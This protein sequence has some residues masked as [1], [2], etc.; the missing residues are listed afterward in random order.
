MLGQ[1][2]EHL[3]LVGVDLD[4]ALSPVTGEIGAWGQKWIDRLA[5]Y[6]EVSPSGAGV[7][8]FGTV[9]QLPAA[10]WD[11]EEGKFKGKEATPPGVGMPEGAEGCGHD[12]AEIGI[13]PCGRYFAFTGQHLPG[14]PAE[15]AD[16]TEAFAEIAAVVVAMGQDDK[17]GEPGSEP[18]TGSSAASIDLGALPAQLRELVEVDPKL[19]DSWARGTKLTKGKDASASGLEF[20]L[21]VYL[22]WREHDDDLI[23]LA[24]RHYPH[25]QIGGGKLTGGNAARRLEKL[26]KEA[27]KTRRKAARWSETK[28]W[29]D[30]LLCTDRGEPRDCLA[31]GELARRIRTGG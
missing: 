28:A 31:N 5:S 25:G 11:D 4:L 19:A 2:A 12:K 15:L 3:W 23:E 8:I 10:L 24:V 27:A 29:Q 26:L 30:D 13:Y 21:V 18:K 22:A 17:A 20:S 7:K 1:V 9:T 6:T 14:T 16:I